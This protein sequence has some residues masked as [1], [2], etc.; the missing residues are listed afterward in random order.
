MKSLFL[1]YSKALTVA[2]DLTV[3]FAKLYQEKFMDLALYNDSYGYFCSALD[4]P[5]AK[6]LEIGCGPGNITMYLIQTKKRPL[7]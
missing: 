3:P 2:F 6:I 1:F 5:Q 7:I 4:K